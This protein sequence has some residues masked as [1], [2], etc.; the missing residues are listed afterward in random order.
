MVNRWADRYLLCRIEK[1]HVGICKVTDLS[2]LDHHDKLCVC[3]FPVCLALSPFLLLVQ[4]KSKPEQSVEPPV[5]LFR[6]PMIQPFRV[7]GPLQL[8]W[9]LHGNVPSGASFLC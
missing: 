1:T 7:T 9:K 2:P 6:W 3:C 5:V 8:P 4:C